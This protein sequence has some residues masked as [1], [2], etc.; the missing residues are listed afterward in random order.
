MGDLYLVVVSA[1][2]AIVTAYDKHAAV[3]KQRR[4]S[5][6]T[7]LALAL[8]GGSGAMY[9]TM[10]FIRHKTRHKRFMWGLPILILVQAMVLTL[11]FR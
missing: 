9:V 6:K 5:E 4:V 10:L 11:L 2:A 3:R 8:I 7:L 1:I